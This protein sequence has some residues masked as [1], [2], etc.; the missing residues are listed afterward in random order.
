MTLE[1][2]THPSGLKNLDF[3]WALVDDSCTAM[4]LMRGARLVSFNA[5]AE[6]LFG[7]NRQTLFERFPLGLSPDRQPSGELSSQ[8]INVRKTRVE[9][10]EPQSFSWQHFRNDGSLFTVIAHLRQVPPSLMGGAA[11]YVMVEMYDASEEQKHRQ[12]HIDAE[13][14]LDVFR[15]MIESA[16]DAMLLVE[17]GR[18]VE[19][20]PAACDLYGLPKDKL[21]LSNPIELS[22][23]RQPDGSFS[24]ERATELMQSA[25]RGEAQSFVWEHLTGEG[26]RFI[27][28]V[29]LNPA[30]N[31]KHPRSG[32][33]KRY[34][35]IVRDITENYRAREQLED[36]NLRLEQRNREVEELLE[37]AHQDP[38]LRI[39]TLVRFIEL[40]GETQLD[41]S[42]KAVAIVD[43]DEFSAINGAL[44]HEFGDC[45]LKVV[46][47]RLARALTGCLIARVGSD[48]FGI[49]GP[50]GM[51]NPVTL[52]GIFSDTFQ[53]SGELLR[54]SAT[55]GLVKLEDHP[56]FGSELLKDAH[57]ALKRA[58]NSARGSSV[59]YSEPMGEDA[60]KRVEL[61]NGLREALHGDQLFLMYQPKVHLADGHPS[62]LEALL[63]WRLPSGDMIP[64]DQFI[65]LAEQSGLI[66]PIGTLVLNTACNYLAECRNQGHQ[67]LVMAINVSQMQLREPD[68]L[69]IL[70]RALAGSGVPPER[71]ELEITES[72]AADDL[73]RITHSL[74]Q[75]MERGVRIAIDDFGTGFSSLSVLTQL[76]ANRLKIDR[77]FIN[78][79]LDDDRIARMVI[80]LGQSLNL[81]ITAEG[82]ETHDQ[83]QA[84]TALQCGEAQGW[85]FARP[86]EGPACLEWL[87]ARR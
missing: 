30:R 50:A 31:L 83:S 62:G 54:L 2:M 74:K 36:L 37:R 63:R 33:R 22:P 46:A 44:G 66:I 4:F 71:V 45:V 21:L 5:S 80:N 72:I 17:N 53:V 8:L 52:H 68:F 26:S 15:E 77:S 32:R 85:H 24:A 19:C 69:D 49:M 51:V 82:V 1:T 87:N 3:F 29:T 39:P 58:K 73:K 35:S 75:I 34:V 61:L 76:P 12:L 16:N 60:R 55:I 7:C 65:P 57:V 27:A 78:D 42:G 84:L 28:E 56:E 79:L 47:E 41:K 64:P 43:I 81:D 9:A 20:N 14:Y 6:R 67:D 25:M 48:V 38:L 59:Y 23:E 40:L 70:D 11:D 10:G 18:I 86:M 13:D